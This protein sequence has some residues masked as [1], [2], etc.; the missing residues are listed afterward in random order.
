[1]RGRPR[2][3]EREVA[4]HIT[5]YLAE[6]G[7]GAVERI[8]ILGRTGPDITVWPGLQIAV[9]VKSRKAIPQS[10]KLYGKHIQTWTSYRPPWIQ[11][12]SRLCD[13]DLLFDI[14]NVEMHLTRN[15]SKT[16]GGW[17]DHMWEWCMDEPAGDVLPALVLHWPGTPVKHS[18]FVIFKYHRSIIDDRRRECL[19]NLR[20]SAS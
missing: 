9:D 7:L 20:L 18:T 11:V 1:M 2:R 12:G 19:D 10:Y 3:I 16:I 6:L 13:L 4:L 14:E 5:Q 17:L 8:P 15:G